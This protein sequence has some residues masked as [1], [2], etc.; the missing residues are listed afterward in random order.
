MMNN[1]VAS[2]SNMILDINI[3]PTLTWR[4]INVHQTGAD[5]IMDTHKVIVRVREIEFI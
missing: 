3:S 4:W 5:P 1:S 2:S